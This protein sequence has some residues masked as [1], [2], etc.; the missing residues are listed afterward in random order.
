MSCMLARAGWSAW[1]WLHAREESRL[2]YRPLEEI[3]AR[4]QRRVQRMVAHAFATVPHYRDAMRQRGLRPDDLRTADS[5]ARLPLIDGQELAEMPERFYSNRYGE[6]ETLTLHSSGTNGRAKAVR[7]DRRALFEALVHGHRQRAVLARFTGRLAAYREMSVIRRESVSVQL[8]R[9]YEDNAFVPRRLD[10]QRRVLALDLPFDEMIRSIN[11]FRP[12]VLGGYGSQLG[13]LMRWAWEREFELHRPR[14][15]WYGA[16]AMP[17]ADRRLVE[18]ELGVP[19]V[20][21]YQADEA[22]RIGF[23]CEHRKGFHL[24]LDDVAV[25]VI[26]PD[27]SPAGPGEQGEIVISNLSNRA[28][29]LLNYRLGDVVTLSTEPCDC[30]RS[31]PTIEAVAGRSNDL[32][33]MPDGQSRHALL[34]MAPLQAVPGVVQVQ[35]LQEHMEAVTVRVVTRADADW[36]PIEAGVRRVAERLLDAGVDIRVRRMADI[37]REP[38]GKTRAVVSHCRPDRA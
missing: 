33:V 15:I 9:Y 2:P 22:L 30:G 10:L 38:S 24:S 35:L 11:D 5:L 23:Q 13:A 21:T 32:L 12:Q 18:D 3:L 29:V 20:S 27:G 26:R 14:V 25:R 6:A 19:V 4:Q 34:F 1:A 7:Y 17:A 37:P 36:P 31:L 28:T 8:R 16:D